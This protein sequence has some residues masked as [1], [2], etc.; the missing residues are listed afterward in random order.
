[1]S[2]R[3]QVGD[4]GFWAMHDAIFA[5]QREGF[6]ALDDA[7]LARYAE[8][9][10]ADGARVLSDLDTG[11]FEEAVEVDFVEG[12]RMGLNGTPTFFIN[13]ERFDGDWRDIEQLATAIEQA[14]VSSMAVSVP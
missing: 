8:E 4:E 6:D 13:G 5:H 10:R 11:K 14:A 2:V 12:V 3:S 9:A 7:H 1:M